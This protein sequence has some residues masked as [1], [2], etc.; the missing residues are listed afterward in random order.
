MPRVG[1]GLNQAVKGHLLVTSNQKLTGLAGSNTSAISA[2]AMMS[3]HFY[4]LMNGVDDSAQEDE[5]EDTYGIFCQLKH[6]AS[7][8]LPAFDQMYKVSVGDKKILHKEAI[9]DC[10]AWLHKCF[11]KK[12]V[13]GLGNGGIVLAVVLAILTASMASLEK[14]KKAFQAIIKD[15]A[16]QAQIATASSSIETFLIT[17]FKARSPGERGSNL[18]GAYPLDCKVF[19]KNLAPPLFQGT[20]YAFNLEAC[21]ASLEKHGWSNLDMTAILKECAPGATNKHGCVISAGKFMDPARGQLTKRIPADPANGIEIDMTMPLDDED[22]TPDMLVTC[23]QV[24][25]IRQDRCA[26]LLTSVQQADAL[27]GWENTTIRSKIPEVLGEEYNLYEL[28][29]SEDY[30][31]RTWAGN[32]WLFE[33]DCLF[34]YFC[35]ALNKAD[36]GQLSDDAIHACEAEGY[37]IENIC[38][39]KGILQFFNYNRPDA[40]KVPSAFLMG[41][42]FDMENDEHMPPDSLDYAPTVWIQPSDTTPPPSPRRGGRGD[43]PDDDDDDDDDDG[44]GG[45]PDGLDR[46]HLGGNGTSS[47]REVNKQSSGQVGRQPSGGTQVRISR[48]ISDGRYVCLQNARRPTTDDD[49][50]DDRVSEVRSNKPPL[51]HAHANASCPFCTGGPLH[52][53]PPPRRRPDGRRGRGE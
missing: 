32:L 43:G 19:R 20:W 51:T 53:A 45:T 26:A 15:V 49:D 35:G 48:E 25:Y 50:D 23:K 7:M 27:Q 46:M 47:S 16:T 39:F 10:S 5:E 1:S 34:G 28:I 41:T 11:G 36:M 2:N 21:I 6:C 22:L 42:V 40:S 8:L 9:Q 4:I 29:C 44:L 3:R 31:P 13:R 17:F 33:E 12:R 37:E 14:R 24:L 38:C 30:E 52:G 18:L